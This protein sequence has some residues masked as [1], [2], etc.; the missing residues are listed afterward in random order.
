LNLTAGEGF[1]EGSYTLINYDGSL[2]N[3]IVG[4]GLRPAGYTFELTVDEIGK[5]V[6]LSVGDANLQ[7]WDG[8]GLISNGTVDGGSG[9]W[10]STN[11]NWTSSSG[12]LNDVWA[13]N[14]AVFGGLVG[15]TVNLTEDVNVAGLQ[16]ATG[17]YLL[18]DGGGDIVIT[19]AQSEMVVDADVTATIATSI[20]GSGALVKTGGGTLVLTGQNTYSGTEVRTGTLTVTGDGAGINHNARDFTIGAANV[21]VLDGADVTAEYV[22]VNGTTAN[23]GVLTVDGV[24][25]TLNVFGIRVSNNGVGEFI[26]Q[27]GASVEVSS[28]VVIGQVGQNVGKVTVS[29]TG[30]VWTTGTSATTSITQG[31]FSVQD[32]ASVMF[33]ELFLGFGDYESKL[34]I[35]G[36]DTTLEMRQQ[37]VVGFMGNGAIEVS[38]GAAVIL[39]G[40]VYIGQGNQGTIT[41]TGKDTTGQ[42]DNT[43]RVAERSNG[44]LNVLDGAV[45]TSRGANIGADGRTTGTVTVSGAGSQ[46]NVDPAS[47]VEI[48]HNSTLNITEGGAFSASRLALNGNATLLVDGAGSALTL[49]TGVFTAQGLNSANITISNGGYV[50]AARST[51]TEN[52]LLTGNN[53]SK[54]TITGAGSTFK[55]EA[56]LHAYNFGDIEVLDGGLLETGRANEYSEQSGTAFTVSGTDSAWVHLGGLRMQNGSSLLI[57][58]GGKVT[59]DIYVHDSIEAL[60]V[61]GANSQLIV[62]PTIGTLLTQEFGDMLMGGAMTVSDGGTVSVKRFYTTAATGNVLV[63]G[64]NSRL[65]T[66]GET[67]VGA[68]DSSITL[69]HGGVLQVDDGVTV[70]G[71]V[72]Y[73]RDETGSSGTLNIGA[74][75]GEAAEAPGT[76]LG[77]VSSTFVGTGLGSVNFN[78]TSTDYT[79]E[80]EIRNNLTLNHYAGVTRLT[81]ENSYN[82]GT[83]IY[84]GLIE[85]TDQSQFGTENITLDGG[86]LRWGTGNTFDISAYLNALGDDG[87]V[88]DTGDNAVVFHTALTGTGGVTKQGAGSLELQ[89]TDSYIGDTH[90]TGGKLV[91]NGSLTSSAIFLSDGG[92]LGGSGIVGTV[93]VNSGGMITPG[94]S[95]GVLTF[96]ELILTPGAILNFELGAPGII[97]GGVNDLIEVTGNLTLDGLVNIADA[98]GFGP[99]SYRLINYGGTLINN[100][101]TLNDV[102]VGVN[103]GNLLLD[104]STNGQVNL[105]YLVTEQQYWDGGD[106]VANGQISGGDGVWSV[107]SNWTNSQGLINGAWAGQTAVFAALPGTVTL[108][109]DIA[110]E[111]LVFESSGYQIVSP[112]GYKLNAPGDATIQVNAGRA[113]ISAPMTIAGNFYKTGGGLLDLR[114]RVSAAATFIQ[115]GRLAVNGVLESPHVDVA[116]GATLQGEGLIIGNV[117][118]SGTVAPGNSIGTLTIDGNYT[119]RRNGTLQ[120]EAASVNHHDVLVVTGT[121]HL[122]GTLEVVSLGY[123]PKFGD[124]IPFLVAGDIRGKFSDI[125]MP[126]ADRF[127]GR[128]V[129]ENGIGVL[130]VAPASYTLVART[131]NE[132][133]V[134]TALD[135][136]IG[137]EDGDIGEVTLALDLLSEELYPVAFEAIAPTFYEAALSVGVELS[138]SHQ[139]QIHQYLN[140]RRL[141]NRVANVPVTPAASGGN[142][143][144]KEVAPLEVDERWSARR[145]PDCSHRVVYRWLLAR[146]LRAALISSERIIWWPTNWPL[147]CS[148]PIRKAGVTMST[149]VTLT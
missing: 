80:S 74:A 76:L 136:W 22:T 149:R 112:Y 5:R 125:E 95:P 64:E 107:G 113:T 25:S 53:T 104:V 142:D 18:A 144:A 119:Q 70:G 139:Q 55:A 115:S 37:A 40:Y 19:N 111:K 4:F 30:T 82:G 12:T 14:T 93:T 116:H 45:L 124:Q 143:A 61:T 1:G 110:F 148:P 77:A 47:H 71:G 49:G 73:L 84:G 32:G 50:T 57:S 68:G 102:P 20:T 69:A 130:L 87:A 33:R 109:S 135:Q 34:T 98:G 88:F 129:A 63:T 117:F 126:S 21:N 99:G 85:F 51:T 145:P 118:N 3:H 91:I 27:N 114:G 41:L 147:V 13:G 75:V 103:P 15:G 6:I 10:N 60:T 67:I 46:W 89:G 97:G 31:E 29:G 140:A 43:L 81:A 48:T 62:G 138:Q 39:R 9:T 38:G 72:L 100:G 122:S 92:T 8:T 11:T 146:T 35:S 44:E 42:F 65:V 2:T 131:P 121:A 36:K 128:F 26:V 127:R 78:H 66:N 28:S 59:T 52:V 54:M 58:E 90:V 101:L 106:G 17:G 120:I 123:A 86:G 134:A 79:F 83:F 23:P 94:N 133:G 105:I 7:F 108:G 141:A 132:Q 56:V 24:G 137:I 96:G 16:F